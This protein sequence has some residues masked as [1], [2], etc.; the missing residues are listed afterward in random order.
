MTDPKTPWWQTA[1][2]YQIYP[3][4][5]CDSNGDGIGDIRGIIS[6]LDH[7]ADLGIGFI[8]LSPVYASPMRDNGYDISD[9]FDI[10][11][12]FGTMADFDAMLAE[13]KRRDIR[14]VMDLVVNHCS[15]DHAWFVKACETTDCPEHEFFYW[16]QARA[17]GGPPDDQ[18][19]C[20]G[21]SAWHWVEAVGKYCYCHFGPQ[22]PDL[23]WHNPAL[24]REIYDMMNW[25][26][27]KGIGGFRMDVIE[28]LGKDLEGRIYCEGPDMHR[29]VQE[30][31][32]ECL[33]GRDIL[34]V[35]ETWAAT[36][37]TA[38]DYC[39]Q[40]RQEL[41]MVFNFNHVQAAWDPVLGRFGPNI[42]DLPTH[43]MIMN[44]WQQ[45]LADDGWNSLYLSN[46]DLPR[47]VS[48]YAD[49]NEFR[50]RSAKMLAMVH[51]LMKGTPFIYQGEEI[52]MTNANFTSLDQ[53]RDIETLGQL[54]EQLG[55]EGSNK[56]NEKSV[57]EF[58]RNANKNGRD[59]ARAPVQWNADQWAGF[60]ECAPWIDINANYKTL[61]VDADRA[62]SD[63]VFSFYQQI[64][65]L[66]KKDPILTHGTFD[67]IAPDLPSIFAYHRRY[68]ARQLT[69]VANFTSE[70][71]DLDLPDLTSI[72]VSP[73]LS[74]A[75][76]DLT[77][78]PS[79]LL[80]FEGF[81]WIEDV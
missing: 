18:R 36:P 76:H 55:P 60:G 35:G 77:A 29:F 10:A 67:L 69:V 78:P 14:I 49:D 41:D 53:F 37:D 3:R 40:D 58:L 23:N 62:D 48:H 47:P 12:E 27:D 17:D 80:P 46:H 38:L 50:V 25:W 68:K 42:F 65:E 61:N 56:R 9:Y 70:T 79:F 59:N 52:G 7:L 43:K 57:D 22:Q 34:T 81:A 28:L 64:I 54:T 74:T 51:Y 21:G 6:K 73:I 30:M 13:A 66:R 19:A 72:K 5:F 33:A 1:T 26:L 71:Q 8:W 75:R 45:A 2:G 16:R 44:D 32:R 39:G 63:G 4:S 15:S 11:P 20:F 24:R 31:H